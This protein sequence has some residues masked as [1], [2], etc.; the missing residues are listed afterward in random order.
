L[1][2][3][4]SGLQRFFSAQRV[5]VILMAV[6]IVVALGIGLW[7]VNADV[8]GDASYSCG[9]G[10][11]HSTH[12]WNVDSRT[13][14]FQ[15]TGDEVA[16]GL[17]ST[18]CPNKVESR[19]DLALLVAAF[20]LA[21]GL[22]AEILLERPRGQARTYRGTLWANRRVGM[23]KTRAPAPKPRSRESSVP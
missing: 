5:V 20:S 9:S 17:P 21:L 6:G 4:V 12:N 19:R 15:R 3:G 13:L 10:F 16:T 18:V 14:E 11:I 2:Q 22:I 8:F 7:P 23:A 1:P